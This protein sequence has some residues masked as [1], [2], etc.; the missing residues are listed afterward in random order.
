M[1]TLEGK[2]KVNDENYD[3]IIDNDSIS[4]GDVWT[5]IEK[6]QRSIYGEYALNRNIVS[7]SYSFFG[8]GETSQSETEQSPNSVFEDE[9]RGVDYEVNVEEYMTF[10]SM[11]EFLQEAVPFV[12]YRKKG[13][14][15]TVRMSYRYEKTLKVFKE[16]PLYIIDGLMTRNTAYFLSLKPEQLLWIKILNHPNKLMQL[17]KL[18]ENAVIFVE[19]KKGDL[20]KPIEGKNI[21]T[22]TGL[23][24]A[25]EFFEYDHG[26]DENIRIPDLRSTL[27]WKPLLETKSGVAEFSF[28]AGD[29]LGPMKVVVTGFT[30]DGRA[31]STEKVIN[32]GFHA[33]GK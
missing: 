16:D 28:F 31:F 9:F 25:R 30:K 18:G 32:V 15:E 20:Y 29:D 26:D 14:T 22:V 17:G 7:K 21:F 10:P 27:Y 4:T 19:S 5:S 33:E 1:S 8:S 2:N 6:E 11:S 13:D 3:I 23:S 12:R 24:R